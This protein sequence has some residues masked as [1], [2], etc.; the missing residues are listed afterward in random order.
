MIRIERIS[1]GQTALYNY[2]E[3]LLIASFPEEEY[4]ELSAMRD[5]TDTKPEFYNN[6]IFNNDI[7]VGFVTYWDLG[8]FYYVEHFAIDPEQRNG[9]YGKKLLNHLFGLLDKP[10]ALEV[11]YPNDELSKRRIN[12]YQREGFELWENEYYQPPYRTGFDK[13]PMYIMVYGDFDS[14]KDFEKVK[15]LI[16]QKVYDYKT[17]K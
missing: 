8:D 17:A 13:L 12:F 15:G 14:K 7:P 9:G 6:I 16:H 1:T 2:M 5:Y 3:R 11:E 4:R 10:I